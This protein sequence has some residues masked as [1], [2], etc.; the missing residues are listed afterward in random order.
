MKDTLLI[1]F[2]PSTFHMACAVTG[3]MIAILSHVSGAPYVNIGLALAILPYVIG[4]VLAA[5]AYFLIG[6]CLVRKMFEA[7]LN[8]SELFRILD[9]GDVSATVEREDEEEE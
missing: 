8:P 1:F 6:A 3:I 5:V 9:N 2:E 4:K 7:G